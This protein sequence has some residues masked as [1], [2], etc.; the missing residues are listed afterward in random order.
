M[1]FVD[2]KHNRFA[3][4]DGVTPIY[5][6]NYMLITTEMNTFAFKINASKIKGDAHVLNS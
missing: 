3:H 1:A 2:M 6:I 5:F 4:S